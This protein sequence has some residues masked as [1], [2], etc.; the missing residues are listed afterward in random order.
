MTIFRGQLIIVIDNDLDAIAS[1]IAIARFWQGKTI[2]LKRVPVSCGSHDTDERIANYL[3]VVP[4]TYNVEMVMCVHKWKD[5]SYSVEF[6]RMG[7]ADFTIYYKDAVLVESIG[8]IPGSP[9]SM[10]V[11]P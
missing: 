10:T 2:S 1:K 3:F 7:G 5:G 8:P 6:G 9:Y 4:G 11:Q